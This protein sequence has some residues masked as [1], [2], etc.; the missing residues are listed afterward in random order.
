MSRGNKREIDRERAAKRS[1]LLAKQ[2]GKEVMDIFIICLSPHNLL[3][4]HAREIP[5]S[6]MKAMRLPLQVY[7]KVPNNTPKI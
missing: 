7:N 6:G 1:E 4:S 2:A 5:R 3:F